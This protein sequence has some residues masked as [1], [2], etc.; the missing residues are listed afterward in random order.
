MCSAK[1]AKRDRERIF[2]SSIDFI[3]DSL[4]QLFVIE[5]TAKS[6]CFMKISTTNGRL[7]IPTLSIV[8]IS[9]D[10]NIAI[11]TCVF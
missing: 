4:N 8:S 7:K 6:I 9:S 1:Y 5:L 2:V 10:Y 11:G 3:K